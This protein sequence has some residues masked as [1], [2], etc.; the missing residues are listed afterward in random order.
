MQL[1]LFDSSSMRVRALQMALE[2]IDPE[3]GQQRLESVLHPEYLDWEPQALKFLHQHPIPQDLDAGYRLWE[4]MQEE[5]FFSRLPDHSA[6]EIRRN[7]FSRLLPSNGAAQEVLRSRQGLSMGYLMLLS[8]DA[9]QA[10]K[11]L[12]KELERFGE[13]ALLRLNLAHANWHCGRK[14]AAR[15][16]F[17][18]ALLLGWNRLDDESIPDATL[19]DALLD[20]DD[21]DWAVIQA[22]VERVLPIARYLSRD[23]FRASEAFQR[24]REVEEN[25]PEDLA[26]QRLQFHCCLVISENR[27]WA[28]HDLLVKARRRMKDLHSRLHF[29]YM[30]SLESKPAA[31]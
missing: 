13:T 31:D 25:P 3:V 30:R 22:C 19:L 17:R 26:G 28:E 6:R 16:H 14:Q 5:P 21:R 27:R 10:A 23:E 24:R 1:D 7:Y 18:Q 11:L 2:Q 12:E 20:A 9:A 4:K 8:G 15:V 29:L